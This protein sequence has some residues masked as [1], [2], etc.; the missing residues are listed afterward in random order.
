MQPGQ[1]GEGDQPGQELPDVTGQPTYNLG[2]FETY[3]PKNEVY[4]SAGQAIVLRVDEANT[5]FVGL[6]S[7]KGGTVTAHLSG[8]TQADPVE[9]TVSHTTDMYYQ[10][11]PVDGY[12]VI[13]NAGTDGGILSI[14]KL[15]TTNLTA[16]AENGGI[17]P[18]TQQ[19]AVTLVEKFARY[20]ANL[21]QQD[22]EETPDTPEQIY[23]SAQEQANANRQIANALF[24]AVRQWLAEKEGV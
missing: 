16:P 3:G 2:T 18:L 21:P 8:L 11:T 23:P 6:K 13:Q 1:E 10:V 20:M 15:R 17:L 24:A 4:L 19:E 14:T 5:Y 12:I 9:I 7:L 22:P